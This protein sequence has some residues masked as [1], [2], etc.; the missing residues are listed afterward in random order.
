MFMFVSAASASSTWLLVNNTSFKRNAARV[1]G[2]AMFAQSVFPG[3]RRRTTSLLVLGNGTNLTQN[4]AVRGGGLFAELRDSTAVI[5]GGSVFTGNEANAGGG[6]FI[7]ITQPSAGAGRSTGQLE[8]GH[9]RWEANTALEDGGGLYVGLPQPEAPLGCWSSAA[10]VA[11]HDMAATGNTAGRAGAG[12]CVTS[13]DTSACGA[14]FAW[15]TQRLT[16][17]C[18]SNSSSSP[19]AVWVG[20]STLVG[21]KAGSTGGA[22]W[23]GPGT[24]ISLSNTSVRGNT[25]V[26][27]PGGGVAA[28]GCTWLGLLDGST[29]DSNAAPQS[30]VFT[31]GCGRVLLQG[32]AVQ[33]NRA[34]AGGGVHLDG[35]TCGD[36]SG[37]NGSRTYRGDPYSGTLAVVANANLS[38]NTADLAV[39]SSAAADANRSAY[40]NSDVPWVGGRGGA[41]YVTGRLAAVL[42]DT[43]LSTN[44]VG[45]FGRGIA[46]TQT[47]DA[48]A[49]PPSPP[50]GV[51]TSPSGP[52]Q[53]LD[54]PL[55]PGL[56]PPF[57]I[58][59]P[60]MLSEPPG[61]P[62]P[63]SAPK[64]PR[65][66][67]RRPPS[68]PFQP[69]SPPPPSPVGSHSCSRSV[70]VRIVWCQHGSASS[71]VGCSYAYSEGQVQVG[72]TAV[73]QCNQPVPSVASC[74]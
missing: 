7:T 51:P 9:S 56:L 30:T 40:N 47:C 58:E 26:E 71:V 46:T 53:V 45:L 63:P 72:A 48:A 62:W 64:S 36:Y 74:N 4:S 29:V 42:T 59:P 13:A 11:V 54:Q 12:L 31:G 5:S 3:S 28:E 14:A 21:N 73:P 61:F 16:F 15:S 17:N 35:G 27:G 50:P 24:S 39:G 23:V 37:S 60:T 69:S 57:Q 68:P 19:A 52:T 2:G 49:P 32:L 43:D 22:L 25:A 55:P 67:R 10:A 44:N 18:S 6:A 70:A 66:P 1:A 33:G 65:Q 8:V 20:N 38:G 34:L 41:L